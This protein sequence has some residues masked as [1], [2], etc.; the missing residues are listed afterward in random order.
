MRKLSLIVI[1]FIMLLILVSCSYKELAPNEQIYISENACRTLVFNRSI[2]GYN[3]S[4][5]FYVITIQENQMF[6][7]QGKIYNDKYT[8]Y[9]LVEN[10]DLN[11]LNAVNG[12]LFFT[13]INGL[14]SVVNHDNEII[15]HAVS[16]VRNGFG[17]VI[18]IIGTPNFINSITT[19]ENR[20]KQNIDNNDIIYAGILTETL[21]LKDSNRVIKKE[22]IIYC[23][24]KS[25]YIDR[26]ETAKI[27]DNYGNEKNEEYEINL[28]I[29]E[30]F[31]VKKGIIID[32]LDQSSTILLLNNNEIVAINN[33]DSSILRLNN[34]TN[35]TQ[36]ESINNHFYVIEN[37]TIYVYNTRLELVLEQKFDNLIVGSCWLKERSDDFIRVATIDQNN[38]ISLHKI[39]IK[40]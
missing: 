4:I 33:F 27:I 1:S 3:N 17:E 10:S 39:Q 37:N 2:H 11:L 16:Y 32:Y 15:E 19:E 7:K 8:Y 35:I 23:S 31:N 38:V 34:H 30:D 6:V 22:I 9:R 13:D 18:P 40:L 20:I 5:S 28:K 12:Q 14:Q 36:I 21:D 24:D 29:D 26:K 25:L